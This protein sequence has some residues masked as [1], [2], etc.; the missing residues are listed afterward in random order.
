LIGIIS[1][2]FNGQ[3]LSGPIPDH[4]RAYIDSLY[5][6]WKLAEYAPGIG[7]NPEIYGR[8]FDLNFIKGDFD[9]DGKIDYALHIEY[10]DPTREDGIGRPMFILLSRESDFEKH[11]I[12]DY[13]DMEVFFW[14]H[15]AGKPV[16]VV[17]TDS[18]FTPMN[19]AIFCMYFEKASELYYYENGEFKIVPTG[20]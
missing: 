3:E 6:D 13:A 18:T 11:I 16:G 1:F 9:G 19:D 14:F 20:D 15:P 8:T 7:I 4:V 5:V 12:H 10:P 17:H 2:V